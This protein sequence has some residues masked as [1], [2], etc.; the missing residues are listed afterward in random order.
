MKAKKA[1]MAK[2]ERVKQKKNCPIKSDKDKT[3][4]ALNVVLR[5]HARVCESFY[6]CKQNMLKN[7]CER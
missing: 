1:K 5:T 2:K 3:N 4:I 7:L 6:E